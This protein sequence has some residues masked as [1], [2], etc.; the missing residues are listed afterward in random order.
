MNFKKCVALAVLL[1]CGLG[2]N[3]RGR[4][5]SGRKAVEEFHRLFNAGQFEEMYR[6]VGPAIRASTSRVQYDEYEKNLQ[7]KLGR[8]ESAEVFNYNVLYLLSG[9][10]VRL[11]YH[12]TFAKG[13]ATESFEIDFKGEQPLINGYR[14]D[15]PVL[16]GKS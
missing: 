1:L 16:N 14:I 10:Q 6:F 4:V 3:P 12:C 2:C 11:D 7:T 15:S 9:P 8:M 13:K 5:E